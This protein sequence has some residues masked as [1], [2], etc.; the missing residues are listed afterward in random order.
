[1]AKQKAVCAY[2]GE[3]K[4]TECEHVVARSFAP[5]ELQDRCKWVCVR[6]CSD[7][8]R[9]YSADEADFRGFATLIDAPN[10]TLV[11]DALFHGAVSRNWQRPEGK[12]ALVRM[13]E[14]IRKR[15]GSGLSSRDELLTVK[16]LGIVPNAG[17]IRVVRKIVRGLYFHH[18]TDTR[19]VSQVL[20]ESQIGVR[21]VYH[22]S[23]E[24]IQLIYDL[25]NLHVIHPMVFV[26]A[27]LDCDEAGLDVPGIDSLWWLYAIKGPVFEV[28]VKS[29]AYPWM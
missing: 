13:L 23:A 9:G 17:V 7:C 3:Y 18:F 22:C 28:F 11:K 10:E 1:M 14:M 25:P 21:P 26:Y 8:N 24:E 4:E 29:N 19:G 27:F 2:C 15:D 16:N 12:N 5:E 6:G 20:Q